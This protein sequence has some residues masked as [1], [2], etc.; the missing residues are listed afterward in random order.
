LTKEISEKPSIDGVLWFTLMKGILIK[1][2]NLIKEKYIMYGLSNKG[3]PGRAME[4]S[5]VFEEINGLREW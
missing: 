2:S 1:H 3:I 4:L 5:P